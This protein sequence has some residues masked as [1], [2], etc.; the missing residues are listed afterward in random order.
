MRLGQ[1]PLIRR[2]WLGLCLGLTLWI[3]GCGGAGSKVNEFFPKRLVVLGDEISYVGCTVV[4]G[5]CHGT[6]ERLDRFS[7]NYDSPPTS[8]LPFFNNWVVM[9]A[10][11]Y[12]LSIDQIIE[13][14]YVTSGEANAVNRRMARKGA[15]VSSIRSQADGLPAYQDGDLLIIAGGANDILC[16]VR[17]TNTS[18]CAS[19]QLRPGLDPYKMIASAQ[20][21]SLGNDKA[22][23]IISAAHSYQQLALDM[24]ARGH[25]NIFVVPVYDFSNSPDLN[26]FCMGCSAVE[27]R[28]ATTLFNIALRAFT[29]AQGAPL[30]FSPGQARILLTTGYTASDSQ[31]VNVTQFTGVVGSF[32]YGF[33]L[34]ASICGS[35]YSVDFA[36]DNCSWNGLF[37][38]TSGIAPVYNGTTYPDTVTG[39][40]RPA[41]LGSAGR[42]VYAADFY[43]APPVQAAIGG[44]FYTFMRGFQ[45]W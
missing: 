28:T 17:N 24:L 9:L 20:A 32:V 45:G 18:N 30:T 21:S 5:V 34:S 35:R 42:V 3:A 11:W 4:N 15:T 41:Y 13:S 7:L 37:A 23:R 25:R 1:S 6:D 29:D 31:Y 16:V 43:L 44:M 19:T 27:L 33:N 39:A 14:S 12:G 2:F 38:E 36:R 22:L 10:R 40:A 8:T 26:S